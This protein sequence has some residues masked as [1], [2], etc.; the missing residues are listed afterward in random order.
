MKKPGKY[1]KPT[2]Y[3]EREIIRAIL[4]KKWD[5]RQNLPPE[6][7]LSELL[8]ITRPTL[9]EV[10]QRLSRDGWISITHGR[11]TKVNDYQ[12]NGGFGI[13][14]TLVKNDSLTSKLFIKE[15]LELR[16]MILPEIAHK[17]I[18]QNKPEIITFLTNA[19]TLNDDCSAY[20]LFDWEL[21]MLLI[22][23]SK[24]TI[25]KMLYNDLTDIYQKESL[26]YFD[27]KEAREASATF[28]RNLEKAMLNDKTT[29]VD[30]VRKAMLKSIKIWEKLSIVKNNKL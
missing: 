15:W 14:K 19:N 21:Q 27:N 29:I 23:S 3:A 8:G 6:R 10:L 9:R 4:E 5:I 7:E 25:V 28:Y 13:L 2:Q 17:A 16:T 1:L 12:N 11:A 18:E 26:L 24:N 20:A 30:I 22:T